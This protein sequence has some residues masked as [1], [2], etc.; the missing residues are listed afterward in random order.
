MDYL[1]PVWEQDKPDTDS[2]RSSLRDLKLESAHF[3]SAAVNELLATLRETHANGGA[4]FGRWRLPPDPTVHWYASRNRLEEMGF[5]P[6]FLTHQKIRADLAVLRIPSVLAR[7][8]K[9]TWT[10]SFTLDGELAHKVYLGG[11]YTSREFTQEATAIAAAA[12]Q[13][14][15][16]FCESL[17]GNRFTELE[18]Y[19]THTPWAPWFHDVAWDATWFGLDKRDR[20]A[21]LLCATDTD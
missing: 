21:W 10:S 11:A 13:L 17:F 12:K 2:I 1:T 3:E 5:F 8:P 4:V 16:R 9:F 20:T 6:A 19:R 15:G 18:V 14:G 7:L